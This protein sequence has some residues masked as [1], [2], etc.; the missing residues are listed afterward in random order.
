[1]LHATWEPPAAIKNGVIG[2][3][4]RYMEISHNIPCSQ[5]EQDIKRGERPTA[6]TTASRF[7]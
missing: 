4:I 7:G 3:S 5:R 2:P 1:M 6:E